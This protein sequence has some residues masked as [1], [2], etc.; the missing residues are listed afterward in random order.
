MWNI[1]RIFLVFH[2]EHFV[3]ANLYWQL[4][5][6]IYLAHMRFVVHTCLCRDRANVIFL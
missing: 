1:H 5:A 4:W 3:S 2:V 6:I